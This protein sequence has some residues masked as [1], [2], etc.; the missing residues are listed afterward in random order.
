MSGQPPQYEIGQIVNGHRWTGATWEPVAAAAPPVQPGPYMAPPGSPGKKSWYKKWWG[1]AVIAF[2]VLMVISL[3]ANGSGGTNEAA[4]EPAAATESTP[5]AEPAEQPA[6]PAAEE[7]PAVDAE[8]VVEAEP[9]ADA[10]AGIGDSVRDGKFEFTAL[11]VET[12]VKKVGT[13]FLDSKAQGA[14]TLVTMKIENIGDEA[15]TFFSDN[16]TGIDSKDRELSSDSEA[17]LYANQDND[18]WISEINPGNSVKAVVVFDVAKGEKLTMIEVH[19][20]LFSG[21]AEIGLK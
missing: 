2:G 10:A 17:T 13:E 18:A 21:G 7:E 8:P 12:G 15:Q 16:I 14:F 20:F 6:E 4:T 9:A 19:D 5:A 3:A 1:V 11:D